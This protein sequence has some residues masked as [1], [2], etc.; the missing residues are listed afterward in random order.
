MRRIVGAAM[1]ALVVA[2]TGCGGSSSSSSTVEQEAIPSNI[3]ARL[4][5]EAQKQLRVRFHDNHVEVT[6]VECERQYTGVSACRL[7][8]VDGQG[9]RGIVTLGIQVNR[10]TRRVNIG[11]TGANNRAW[12]KLLSTREAR[13]QEEAT[14]AIETRREAEERRLER[15]LRE[16][17][18]R[19]RARTTG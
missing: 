3:Q 11:F 17:A 13:A 10:A 9:R 5:I 2:T 7:K 18:A 8:V 16:Q 6:D 4:G 1:V 14:R 15:R 12:L 19:R